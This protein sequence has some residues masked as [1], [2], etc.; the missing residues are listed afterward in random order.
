MRHHAESLLSL[1][2]GQRGD[3]GVHHVPTSAPEQTVA[4][5]PQ[6]RMAQ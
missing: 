2:V 3:G 6:I 1:V 5:A 4:A